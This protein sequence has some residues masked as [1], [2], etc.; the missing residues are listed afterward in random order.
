M[1][2]Y[3]GTIFYRIAEKLSDCL[4]VNC[5][6]WL[7]GEICE[8][9]GA[10]PML[11]NLGIKTD[12][13]SIAREIDQYFDQFRVWNGVSALSKAEL[14]M[15]KVSSNWKDLTLTELLESGLPVELA[16]TAL[17]GTRYQDFDKLKTKIDPLPQIFDSMRDFRERHI[18]QSE[19]TD[20][21]SRE[22]AQSS[23]KVN[24]FSL[25]NQKK[26]KKK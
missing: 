21:N 22:S 17:E 3:E 5:H 6:H 14:A 11:I 8:L 9:V 25:Q 15:D 1:N 7:A 2:D 13:R 4:R 18:Q 12:C 16:V 26:P 23:V 20:I 10:H 24:C 19:N